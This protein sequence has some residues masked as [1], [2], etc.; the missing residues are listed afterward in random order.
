MSH[1]IKAPTNRV[2]LRR[3]H[4]RGSYDDQ[5][6]HQIVDAT[7]QCSVGYVKDGHPYVTST[8]HWREGNHLYWHGSS[9]SG[10]LR[11]S[12]DADVCV[13]ISILDGFVMARSGFHH[14]IN[15]RSVMI[16]G[17]AHKVVD[18]DEKTD[19]LKSFVEGLF[20][21]RWDTLR[22]PTIQEMKA[23]TILG[24]SLDEASAKVRTGQPIDDEG[25]YDLPIWS[26]VIPVETIVGE[27]V[28]DPKNLPGVRVPGHISGFSF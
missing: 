5:S 20:P 23:T 7:S 18:P 15:Y 11:A 9:A 12:T 3:A 8:V 22:P 14:S 16:F 25:D 13:N 17:K 2:R 4:Q 27:P 26:G 24:M 19:R 28:S 6:I 21:G 10:M 1:D